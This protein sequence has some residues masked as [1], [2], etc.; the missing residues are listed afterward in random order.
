MASVNAGHPIKVFKSLKILMG[1]FSRRT[2]MDDAPRV[3]LL[4]FGLVMAMQREKALLTAKDIED[5]Q[6]A[7]EL[8]GGDTARAA[9]LLRSDMSLAKA[10]AAIQAA[11]AK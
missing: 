1:I 7:L 11:R 6:A 2:T 3:Y 5:A 10:A 9:A 8:T 4:P